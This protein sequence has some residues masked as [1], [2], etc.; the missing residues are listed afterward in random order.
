MIM[1]THNGWRGVM[2]PPPDPLAGIGGAL[3]H[4]FRIERTARTAGPFQ[5]L[6]VCLD[7]I[8]DREHR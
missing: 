4:A 1:V 8:E 5:E 6:V 3:R 7:R 2:T